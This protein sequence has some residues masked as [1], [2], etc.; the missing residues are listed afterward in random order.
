MTVDL[1][2]LQSAIEH[3]QA[4]RLAQ[5]ER[6]YRQLL[7]IDPNAPDV[8]HL[9][10]VIAYQAGRPSL[11]VDYIRRAIGLSDQC[12]AY[13]GNLGAAYRAQHDFAKAESA[14]QQALKLDPNF[15]DAL[16][17]YAL[18]LHTCGRL[19]EALAHFQ[20]ALVIHPQLAAL[21]QCQAK[22]LDDL[23]R[24]DEAREA[25][26]R[27]ATLAQA[28]ANTGEFAAAQNCLDQLAVRDY[29]AGNL[30]A[31]CTTFRRIVELAPN[32]ISA[33]NN[34]AALLVEL[35]Q[36]DEA[37]RVAQRG[38]QLDSRHSD[39]WNNLGSA[40][41]R[42]GLQRE[43][44]RS[45]RKAIEANAN[46]VDALHNLA[47]L[48]IDQRQFDAA[49][50][51]LEQ[52]VQLKPDAE[53]IAKTLAALY[54]QQ[55]K[56]DQATAVAQR[57]MQL[58]KVETSRHL[59]T[60]VQ[61][62]HHGEPAA[63]ASAFQRVL[64][65]DPQHAIAHSN[66]LF[67]QLYLPEN[68][69]ERLLEMHREFDRRHVQPLASKIS[70]EALRAAPAFARHASRSL[71]RPLRIGFVSGDLR[72]HPVGYLTLPLLKDLDRREVFTA[73][74]SNRTSTDDTQAA[75]RQHADLWRDVL[76]LSDEAVT[77][78]I[79]RDEIDIL[80][81]RSGHTSENRLLVFAR[82]AAPVQVAWLAY[83][84]TTGVSTIDFLMS[85]RGTIPPEHEAHFS[86]RIIY[87]PE[88]AI[89]F[90][91]PESLPLVTPPPALGRT[92]LTF[93]SFNNPSKLHRGV[94]RLWSDIL[95]QLPLSRLVLKY[96]GLEEPGTQQRL[97]EW[98]AEC[99]VSRRRLEF[100]GETPLEDMLAEYGR[101]DIALDT[102]PFCGGMTTL[103]ALAMGVPVVT[104]PGST[105]SSRQSL[106]ILESLGLG[107]LAASSAANFV[108][109]TVALALNPIHIS[110]LR[111]NLRPRLL[112]SP[113]C[114][115]PR[116]AANFTTALQTAWLSNLAKR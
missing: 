33:L 101:I 75:L 95:E 65:L 93:G 111:Q 29:R 1:A 83:P 112:A 94:V 45:F 55:G 80:I 104:L 87:L 88:N 15:G 9:L 82:R 59:D 100:Q 108:E 74:Y 28:A 30:A 13:Y 20:R 110:D 51:L 44:E 115:A 77:E 72:A 96:R 35:K 73:C 64:Q 90:A 36:H 107:E 85:D 79:R 60:G 113:L 47:R 92:S 34:L 84:A 53:S 21:H 10:G 99:G 2:L 54:R 19:D 97:A 103:F 61:L 67:A 105:M 37:A 7:A 3:H 106:A 27:A 52:A 41:Y 56:A 11:A 62:L 18:L 76:S 116:F 6:I 14:F 48:Q 4:G 70:G 91:L 49:T 25:Y 58:R 42:G 98:F 17:N 31:A 38:L 24:I 68:T 57:A 69:P 23:G 46:N 5:A 89:C 22:V 78:Q 43:A 40:Q 12:A 102:F 81:D 66:Y 32:S 63:A 50:Q 109:R 16:R 26:F 8:W 71:T 86:E 39:L 114:D